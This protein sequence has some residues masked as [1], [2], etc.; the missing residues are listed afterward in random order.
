LTVPILLGAIA[1]HA[2]SVSLLLVGARWL[3]IQ[4]R[5]GYPD[6][7]ARVVDRRGLLLGIGAAWLWAQAL[8]V[9][10]AVLV[11]ARGA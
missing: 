10:G 7:R 2:L 6:P 3:G 8:I 1:F 4:R 11:A 9:I 5:L